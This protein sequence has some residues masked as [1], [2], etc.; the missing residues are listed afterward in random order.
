MDIFIFH[1][2][3]EEIK[4]QKSSQ[5]FNISK[6]VNQTANSH[7][8]TLQSLSG[9]MDLGQYMISVTVTATVAILF[10]LHTLILK[11]YDWE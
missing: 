2:M 3:D 7:T 8:Y 1:F 11:N 4:T 9:D 10:Q 6:L 5:L